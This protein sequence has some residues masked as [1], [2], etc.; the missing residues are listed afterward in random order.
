M[1]VNFLYLA[2]KMVGVL[3]LLPIVVIFF[4]SLQGP[5]MPSGFSVGKT[6]LSK[7]SLKMKTIMERCQ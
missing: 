6:G 5:S 7:F 4:V 1:F 2:N 3:L